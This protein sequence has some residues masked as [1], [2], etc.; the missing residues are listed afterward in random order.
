MKLIRLTSIENR[1][2]AIVVNEIMSVE[3]GDYISEYD[4]DGREY[5]FNGCPTR[6]FLKNFKYSVREDFETVCALV[7]GADEKER[8]M[9]P[10]LVPYDENMPK[11][12]NK[13]ICVRCG[14]RANFADRLKSDIQYDLLCL[15]ETTSSGYM[16]HGNVKLCGKCMSELLMWLNADDF[17]SYGER[18]VSE[19]PTGS[20]IPNN[21]ND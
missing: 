18:K 4:R 6:V 11:G 10:I 2:I 19:K 20:D 8:E 7:E 16:T 21:S 3:R 14:K 17:C 15:A 13:D 1:K 12:R 9:K 5:G